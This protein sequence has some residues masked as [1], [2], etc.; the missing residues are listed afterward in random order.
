[1]HDSINQGDSDFSALISKMKQAGV[2]VIYFGGYY[3]EAGLIVRQAKEQ[4][5]DAVL[6]G[7]DALVTT[8]LWK[9]TGMAGTGTLMTFPPDPRNLAAAQA[10]VKEFK[11]AGYDPEGYTLYTYAAIQ[12]FAD[13]ANKAKS[14]KVA[15]LSKTMKANKF[16]TVIGTIGF[17]KKGDV[18]GPDYVVYAWNNSGNYAELKR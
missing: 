1:V 14:I 6:M 16:N 9:I 8:D 5:L 13:A 10:V 17:D 18:I 11:A 3:R 12:V 4:G 15:D 7:G 2:K